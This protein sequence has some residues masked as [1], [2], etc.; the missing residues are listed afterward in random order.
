IMW[1]PVGGPGLLD[2]DTAC[3]GERE[4]DLGNLRAHARWRTHQEIWTDDEAEAVIGE[5][6]RVTSE[7]GLDPRRVSAYERSTLLRLVCVYAFR[8]RFSDRTGVLLEAAR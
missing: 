8:P 7:S 4:L 1:D 2:V 6:S 3:L 5:I